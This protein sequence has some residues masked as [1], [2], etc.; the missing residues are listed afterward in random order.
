M[1]EL[2]QKLDPDTIEAAK[3]LLRTGAIAGLVL[4]PGAPSPYSSWEG[5]VR[6]IH[7][8]LRHRKG[9]IVGWQ[10]LDK[11]YG[12]HTH[13]ALVGKSKQFREWGIHDWWDL[14]YGP[15]VER[16]RITREMVGL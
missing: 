3:H 14:R 2:F 12:N 5:L 10:D 1:P 6:D 9:V 4:L 16:F 15:D 8:A 13:F 11:Y 7:V